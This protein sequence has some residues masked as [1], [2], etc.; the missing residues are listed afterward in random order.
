[1][2]RLLASTMMMLMM[3]AALAGCA[4]SDQQDEIDTLEAQ[5]TTDAATIADLQDQLATTQ[6]ALDAANS[7]EEITQADVDA[8]AD[9]ARQEGIDS[10]D[11]TTDNQAAADA[12]VAAATQSTLCLL[13]TSPSPRDRG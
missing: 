9:A 8:A 5:A 1:M 11:I 13:Y 12:A 2:Q 4:G 10:V 3:T 7:G 6:A